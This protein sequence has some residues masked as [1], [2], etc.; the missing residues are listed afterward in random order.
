MSLPVGSLFTSTRGM[1]Y[2][3][4]FFSKLPFLFSD[5]PYY[6]QNP[7][8]IKLQQLLIMLSHITV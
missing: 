3:D 2:E 4:M 7:L 6:T 5:L 8:Y 1:Q